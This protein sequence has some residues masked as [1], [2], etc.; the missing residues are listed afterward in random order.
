MNTPV[1]ENSLVFVLGAGFNVDA[2]SEAGNPAGAYPR[3]P[4]YPMAAELRRLCFSLDADPQKTVEDLFQ[5]SI[6]AVRGDDMVP[7]PLKE[8]YNFL[9]EADYFITPHLWT[10][11]D[12]EENIYLKFLRDFPNAPLLTF[13]YDSLPEILLLWERRWTPRKGYG[14]KVRAEYVGVERTFARSC[15]HVLHLHGSLC[16][17]TGPFEIDGGLLREREVPEYCF[18]PDNVADRFRPFIRWPL[19]IAND[20]TDAYRVIAPIPN[21]AG[22]L[23]APFIKAVYERAVHLVRAATQIVSIGYSFNP[24]DL[25]SYGSLLEAAANK[26]ILIVDPHADSLVERLGSDFRDILCAAKCMTFREWV[27]REYP[28]LGNNQPSS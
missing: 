21:K 26:S 11:G 9:R 27:R 19:D 7:L 12:H 3:P 18:D 17:Y 28:G 16:V 24:Y 1:T 15:R 22:K 23:S 4:G 6:D 14:V 10:G 2:A 25:C 5:E 13:N 8:L 20:R